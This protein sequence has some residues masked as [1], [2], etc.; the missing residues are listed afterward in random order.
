MSF[1]EEEPEEER[2]EEQDPSFRKV[3][4]RHRAEPEP[5]EQQAAE[6]SEPEAVEEAPEEEAVAREEAVPAEE[7]GPTDEAVTLGDLSVYDTLRFAAGLLI[8]Q[9]WIQM[10]VQLAPGAAELKQD[11]VQAKVAID[12]LEFVVAK[13]EPELDEHEQAEYESILANLRINYVKKA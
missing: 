9:A 7:T 1:R 8:Q 2:E 3:D 12:S 4:K 10:G 11:L 5:E 13:L 6:S